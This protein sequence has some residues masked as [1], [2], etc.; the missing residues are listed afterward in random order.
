MGERVRLILD[1]E[2][3]LAEAADVIDAVLGR[4]RDAG[5]GLDR[6]YRILAGSRLAGEHDRAG[7]VVDRVGD[8]GGLGAG[9]ARAVDHGFQHLGG[10]DDALAEEAAAGNKILLHRRKPVKRNLDAHVA[11]GDHDAFAFLADLFDVVVAGLVFNL[12]DELDTLAAAFIDEIPDV[13]E[14]LADGDEGAGDEIYVIFNTET[15]IALVL[16]GEINLLED[17]AR[18]AHGLAVREFAAFDDFRDDLGV[19]RGFDFE[20]QK[21]VIEKDPVAGVQL[22]R[23]VF[24]ADGDDVFISYNVAG[25]E[26][27]RAAGCKVDLAVYERADTVFGAFGVEEDCDRKVQLAAD[28]FDAVDTYEVFFMGA[29]GEVQS[30]HVHAGFGECGEHLFGVRGGADGA[31]DLGFSHM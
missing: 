7:A 6:K 28:L 16:L 24:V 3:I 14:V 22:D 13:D 11:A 10:G 30:G 20:D 31:D 17:T 8:V 2:L 23:E 27:E 4:L 5:H 21:A 15:D 19:G 12:C 29:V 26:G 18:E 9:R 25:R 1:H